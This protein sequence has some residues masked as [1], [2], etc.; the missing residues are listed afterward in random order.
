[1][2]K[3]ILILICL[4]ILI[5]SCQKKYS[6][7]NSIDYTKKYSV[8]DIKGKY[9]LQNSFIINDG[10]THNIE[11]LTKDTFE[12]NDKLTYCYENNDKC[13]NLEYKLVGDNNEYIFVNTDNIEYSPFY[14]ILFCEDN[15][16]ITVY[17]DGSY[18]IYY[19]FER[20]LS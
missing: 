15:K 14:K 17:E 18:R 20:T 12:I 10:I 1:M 16:L 13:Y 9:V 19:F 2:K 3:K 5:C 11:N 7:D 8:N 6:V 4:C